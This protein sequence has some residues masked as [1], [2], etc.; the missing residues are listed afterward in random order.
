MEIKKAMI[1]QSSLFFF[2]PISVFCHFNCVFQTHIHNIRD[3]V[4]IFVYSL[5]G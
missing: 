5:G 1:V 4:L 3:T 2:K